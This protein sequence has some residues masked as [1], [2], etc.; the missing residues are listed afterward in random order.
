MRTLAQPRA[1]ERPA[2]AQRVGRGVFDGIEER[3]PPPGVGWDPFIASGSKLGAA[4]VRHWRL[5]QG[6]V[7]AA[8]ELKVLDMHPRCIWQQS[9]AGLQA[10]ICA[11]V[12]NQRHAR[13]LQNLASGP[14]ACRMRHVVLNVTL[15]SMV[16]C[17][18][19]PSGG[20]WCRSRSG[21]S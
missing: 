21:L 9:E 15:E 16:W 18:A 7:A 11:D 3:S 14:A 10:D 8:R 13:L 6:E 17:W 20:A 4:L 5:L 1:L 12:E 19:L 2:I